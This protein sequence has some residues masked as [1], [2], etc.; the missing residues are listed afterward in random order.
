MKRLR[1]IVAALFAAVL[2]QPLTLVSVTGVGE[3]DSHCGVSYYLSQ[4]CPC[5]RHPQ[6]L[7]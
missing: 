4:Q 3:V 6:D 1:Q 2:L 7:F 5:S